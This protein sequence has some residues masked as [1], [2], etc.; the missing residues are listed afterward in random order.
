MARHVTQKQLKEAGR[1]SRERSAARA[2]ARG[3]GDGRVFGVDPTT[4]RDARALG[5]VILWTGGEIGRPLRARRPCYCGCDGS[6]VGY[7]STSDER[8]NGITLWFKTEAEYQ[9]AHAMY[10]GDA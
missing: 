3:L 9:A 5:R 6:G 1:R 10:G 2:K 4:V 7:L 8:G